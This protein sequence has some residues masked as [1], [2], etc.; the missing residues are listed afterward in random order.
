VAADNR[1]VTAARQKKE[2]TPPGPDDLVRES[3]GRYRTGD[4]R[5][6]IQKSDQGWFL[7][8]SDEANEFGQQ[9]I[10]GPLATL[11]A[12]KAAI[13]GSR[14]I[15]PLLRVRPKTV[16]KKASSATK[17]GTAAATAPPPPPPSWI[18][19]LPDKE[20]R[21]ARQLIV[22]LGKEGFDDAE[23][24]VRRGRG[25]ATPVI[26]TQVVEQRLRALVSQQPEEDR[27]RALKLVRQAAKILA[28]DGTSNEAPTPRWALIEI[29]SDDPAPAVKMRPRP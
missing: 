25:A 2:K 18:D 16:R 22:A 4:G 29:Q 15:K 5:F 11:D 21:Q 6:E 19:K 9:L 7:I 10:H 20:A 12:I 28:E 13:P 27:E 3:A 17:P 8:D 24:V 1:R 14:E 23:L 26:A